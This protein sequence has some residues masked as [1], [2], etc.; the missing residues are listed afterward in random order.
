MKLLLINNYKYASTINMGSIILIQKYLISNG[1]YTS[2]KPVFGKKYE[3]N[4]FSWIW[5]KYFQL[6]L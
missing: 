5:T 3:L 1:D 6:K 2:F 4:I